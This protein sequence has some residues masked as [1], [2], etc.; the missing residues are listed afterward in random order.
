MY[1]KII[2]LYIKWG[3][4]FFLNVLSYK[5]SELLIYHIGPKDG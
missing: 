4:A 1:E 5:L 2:N 3:H